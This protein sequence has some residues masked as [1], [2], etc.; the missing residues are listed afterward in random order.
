[1]GKGRGE[2][3]C[4]TEVDGRGCSEEQRGT[5]NDCPAL[6]LVRRTMIVKLSHT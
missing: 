1:M 2:C 6:P 3:A 4:P 5:E